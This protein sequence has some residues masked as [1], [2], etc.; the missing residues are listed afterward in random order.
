VRSP[1][2]PRPTERHEL[3]TEAAPR[4]HR[5]L[6]VALFV[7]ACVLIFPNLGDRNLWQDEAETAL[8]AKNILRTGLPLGWDGR[9]FVTQLSGAEMTASYLWAWTPWL[10]HYV[11][12]LGMGVAGQTAFGARWPFALAGCFSFPLFYRV[13]DY[14]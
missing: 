10:M 13:T 2:G 1:S 9:Q 14:H 3:D 4:L 12:A 7:I 11:A 5:L 6:P 8:I